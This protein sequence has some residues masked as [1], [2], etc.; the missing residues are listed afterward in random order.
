MRI[1][2]NVRNSIRKIIKEALKPVPKVGDRLYC[3]NNELPFGRYPRGIIN[4]FTVGHYYNVVS[5]GGSRDNIKISDN[6]SVVH[7]FSIRKDDN[8]LNYEYWFTLVPPDIQNMDFFKGL[9]ESENDLGWVKDLDFS[10]YL[11]VG[12]KFSIPTK[13]SD[14]Q[15]ITAVITKVTDRVVFVLPTNLL[16]TS[17]PSLGTSFSFDR[18]LKILGKG[19]WKV[20]N[21]NLN[22]DFNNELTPKVR[23]ILYCHTDLV[24]DYGGEINARAG[25]EYEII[26]I[27]N[28]GITIINDYNERHRFTLK[29]E[30]NS[31]YENWFTL[32]PLDIQNMDFFKNLYESE[33]EFDW[34]GNDITS[35]VR[36]TVK[37]ESGYDDKRLYEGLKTVID[38]WNES[39]GKKFNT[40]VYWIRGGIRKWEYRRDEKAMLYSIELMLT[41]EHSI[42]IQ[43]E[44]IYY[45]SYKAKGDDA[46]VDQKKFPTRYSP[47]L[48]DAL[49]FLTECLEKKSTKKITE[50]EEFEWVKDLGKPKRILF[51]DL[52]V[53]M[54]VMVGGLYDG[55]LK[56]NNN[57]GRIYK[58][59]SRSE[60]HHTFIV[61]DDWHG[62][63]NDQ[64]KIHGDRTPH[65]GCKT[66]NCYYFSDGNGL[67]FYT[68]G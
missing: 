57:T 6:N 39:N 46:F 26:D 5:G 16:N 14:N 13:T 63:H 19:D 54:T 41:N 66:R 24:M 38:R 11:K 55:H 21:D 58:D 67:K 53:G 29:K 17:Y 34:I 50:S 64:H 8:D 49:E 15:S 2:I 40:F 60:S 18:I 32:I 37:N 68:I 45:L 48:D 10:K 12:Q 30:D 59:S 27:D 33:D 62:G 52:K 61:F 31:N 1:F 44:W 25:K 65:P 42:L 43:D 23:D 7:N 22:E 20:I 28:R 47:N 35:D 51:K 56:F 36:V 9:Y 4:S 3:Y